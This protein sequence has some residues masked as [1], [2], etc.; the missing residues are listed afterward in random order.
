MDVHLVCEDSIRILVK[1][2]MVLN[3]FRS[4]RLH[5][6]FSV[7]NFGKLSEYLQSKSDRCPCYNGTMIVRLVPL[8]L[9]LISLGVS[10]PKAN[11]GIIDFCLGLLGGKSE[12]T[13]HDPYLESA[14]NVSERLVRDRVATDL[15]LNENDA[16]IEWE[17]TSVGAADM[18]SYPPNI[19]VHVQYQV[20]G[21]GQFRYQVKWSLLQRPYRFI[22]TVP[23]NSEQPN[24]QPRQRR[25]FWGSWFQE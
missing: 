2:N 22:E 10:A 5:S 7:T 15:S 4:Y 25:S 12:V 13:R 6:I 8:F 20:R 1:S 18:N 17:K 9:V 16:R 19:S 3:R 21:I 14:M 23:A 24:S 11:A